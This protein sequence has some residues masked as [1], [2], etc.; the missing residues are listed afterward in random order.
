MDTPNQPASSLAEAH[1]QIE[2]L[3]RQLAEARDVRDFLNR[4]LDR[5]AGGRAA[6]KLGRGK[7][8]AELLVR[9]H[10]LHFDHG[11]TAYGIAKTFYCSQSSI[12]SFLQGYY[13]TDAAT[14]AY[15]RL[16]ITPAYLQAQAAKGGQPS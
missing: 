5:S 1:E 2:D 7:L 12:R 6:A 15:R 10:Q 16:G 14:E 4:A 9:A 11:M 3:K 8:T 13:S